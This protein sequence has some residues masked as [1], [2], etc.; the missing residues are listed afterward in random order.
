MAYK[1]ILFRR[2]L[3]A[4]WTSVDPVLS[5]GEI[6]LE[7]DTGKIKLG[8]GSTEWTELDYFYGSLENANYVESLVAGT[9]LTITG[10]SGSGSTP[11]I[12]LP[13]SVGTS[14]SPTFAQITIGNLPVNDSHVATKAYVDGIAASIN[15]HQFAQLATLIELPNTPTYDNGTNGVGAR[16]TASSN[17]RLFID[18]TNAS[19]GNRIVVKNQANT[20]H[21]GVYDVIAQGSVSA[22]WVLERSSDFDSSTFNAEIQAGEALY[23]GGGAVNVNQ[24][25]LVFSSGTGADGSHIIGTDAIQFTQFSGTAPILAGTGIVKNGNTLAIGQNVSTSS[26]V[27]FAGILAPFLNGVAAE[28]NRLNNPVLIGGQSFDGSQNIVLGTSDIY[29]LLATSADLNKLFE[30]GTTKAQLEFLNTASA[31]IQLQLNEKSELLNPIFYENITA[32]NNIYASEFVGNLVGTHFG[33]LIGT[34]DGDVTGTF[35]GSASG[36]FYGQLNGNVVGNLSGDTT[37]LHIGNVTGDVI[38]NVLGNVTGSVSGDVLGNL[39]GNVFGN[40]TGNLTGNVTGSVDGSISGNAATV[41][42][43]SNHGLDG[44]SDVSVA[45]PTNGQFLKWNG[46]AWV[47]D[48]V[49]LNTDTSGNYVASVIAGTGVSLANAVAQDR[50]SVV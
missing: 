27:I 22:P 13:Q 20:I 12:S 37:G 41:S 30:L 15:W 36:S 21:N 29:G 40:V 48:L 45:S 10:N 9:G 44:L 4:T 46:T 19:N 2:D 28:A 11:T 1:K 23:V 47:P 5:A 31:N 43:I 38:G 8:D 25:F 35:D 33:E 14:A 34:V 6:G 16:L 3:A 24:G 42:T 50:K 7:S 18:G 32:N 17:E 26:S 49:D 39:T